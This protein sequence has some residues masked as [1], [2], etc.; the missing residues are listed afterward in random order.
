MLLVISINEEIFEGNA[1]YIEQNVKLELSILN[2]EIKSSLPKLQKQVLEQERFASRVDSIVETQLTAV[3]KVD[4]YHSHLDNQETNPVTHTDEEN[5]RYI[6][7]LLTLSYKDMEELTSSYQTKTVALRERKVVSE[8]SQ[9]E[10]IDGIKVQINVLRR[11][12][13]ELVQSKNSCQRSLNSYRSS[14]I[15]E[16]GRVQYLLDEIEKYKQLIN[17]YHSD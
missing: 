10:Q 7:Y 3:K 5:E 13:S 16:E 1:K 17:D 12:I 15:Q 6:S 4:F 2:E 8:D 11:E 9:K 14:C